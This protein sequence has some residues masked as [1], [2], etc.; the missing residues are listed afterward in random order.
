MDESSWK[1][2]AELYRTLNV[3]RAAER[4]F[5]TQPNL[6]KKLQGIE[7]HL[8]IKLVLRSQK[9]VVFTPEGE[10]IA[11]EAS[12]VLAHFD[13]V[14]RHLLKIGD[15]HAGLIKLGMTNAFARYTL[16]PCLKRYKAHHAEVGFDISTEISSHIVRQLED[17]IIHVGFIRGDFEGGFERQ[18]MATEQAYLVNGEP[19]ELSELPKLPQISYLSDPISRRLLDNWWSN[20]FPKPPL[21]GMRANHGDTCLEMIANGLGYG[22]FLSP[23]FLGPSASLFKCPL[24]YAD[25]SPFERQ[26]WMIWKKDSAEIPLVA[27]FLRYMKDE[28]QSGLM[29]DFAA[30]S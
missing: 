26:S 7:N 17:D 22:I 1:I 14:R 29:A 30:P 13:E 24:F 3:T 20:H 27:R 5:M 4:L 9:G 16:P 25:G 18:L 10:Y 23:N 12:K 11:Q 2:I 19:I 15:G 28:I 6:S 8:G 21:I